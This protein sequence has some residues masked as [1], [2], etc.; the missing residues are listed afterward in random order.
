MFREPQN[1]R[2]RLLLALG[3]MALGAAGFA[4][5]PADALAG[6]Q[7]P[8]VLVSQAQALLRD[9]A[10]SFPGR[11]VI[12]VAAPSPQF[13]QPACA[14]LET[15]LSGTGDLQP[16]T[17]VEIRC[18]APRPWTTYLQASVQ[19]IGRYFVAKHALQRGEALTRED[20]D[21]REGDLLRNRRLV[22]DEGALLGWI[23]TRAI[24][25]G[26]A[27]ESGALRDPNAIQRGQQVRAVARGA[28]FMAS[29]EG[30]ALESGSPGAQIQVRTTGGR[31]IS[32]TIVDAHTVQV[33]M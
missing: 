18:L 15:H 32:G 28:G 9:R 16:R 21:S 30:Q 4:Q 8:A 31:I 7:D 24:R 33:M 27:I 29:S 13:N 14:Q 6:R 20:V 12:T 2:T 25:A 11:A 3:L 23:T 17:A 19:V 22:V 5:T 10:A 1:L 26:G